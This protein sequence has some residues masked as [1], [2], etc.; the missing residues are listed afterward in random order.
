MSK[1][2]FGMFFVSAIGAGMIA[3]LAYQSLLMGE[4]AIGADARWVQQDGETIDVVEVSPAEETPDTTVNGKA[5]APRY[6]RTIRVGGGG[7]TVNEE[8]VAI[9]STG[10][11]TIEPA[12]AGTHTYG[13]TMIAPNAAMQEADGAVVK[14]LREYQTAEEGDREAVVAKIKKAVTKQF[15]SR[16]EARSNELKALE[17]QLAK[18]KEKHAKRESMKDKIV[19]DRVEQLVD[20]VDGLGWGTDPVPSGASGWM[21]PGLLEQAWPARFGP[22]SPLS[23]TRAGVLPALSLPAA[24]PEPAVAPAAPL[25]PAGGR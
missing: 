20:N 11:D 5:S 16:Q 14:L 3:N 23:T 21:S 8:G 9:Y 12:M 10:P 22:A 15:E 6:R 19:S 2:W 1:K 17:E 18:L 4:V 13:V 25:A 24:P 7:E